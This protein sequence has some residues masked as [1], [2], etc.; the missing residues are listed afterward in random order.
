LPPNELPRQ[1][2]AATAT[3]RLQLGIVL[4]IW[5][6]MLA[7]ALGLVT[8]YGSNVPSWD[9]WDMV[10]FVTGHHPITMKWLWS[11]HNEHRVLLP[12][13]LFL[14]L[15]RLVTMDFRIGMYANVLGTGVLALALIFSARRLRGRS[16]FLDAFFP[17]LLLNWGQAANILWC[18]QLQFY[19][20]MLLAG[21]ILALISCALT[22]PKLLPSAAVGTCVLL[23]PLCGANGVSLVPALALWLE[24]GAVLH[25]RTGTRLG[26]RNA[27]ILSVFA[28]LGVLFVG[29]YFLGYH[30]V[31]YHP[32]TY[33][34][35]SVCRTAV[36]FITM[37]FG[38]GVVGLGFDR[39]LPM[40]LWEIVCAAVAVL[41]VLT[42]WRLV[43]TWRTQP[44]ECARAAG[45]VLYLAAMLSLALGIGLGRNGF[46]TRYVTLSVP[47]L[48][49]VYLAWSIYGSLHMQ[50]VVRAALFVTSAIVLFPNIGWGLLYARDLRSH[51]AAFEKD[52]LTGMPP[53]QLIQRHARYLHLHHTVLMDYMPMLRR[54]GVGSFRYLGDDPLFREIRLAAEGAAGARTQDCTDRPD[55]SGGWF[56]FAL[57]TDVD[58]AGIRLS[59]M[60]KSVEGTAPYVVICWKST[61]E[62]DFGADSYIAYSPSGDQANWER[63]TWLRS[64]TD[65]SVVYVWLGRPVHQVRVWFPVRSGTTAK[66]H[67]VALLV[68]V[69]NRP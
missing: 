10:P 12:R 53:Y 24:Y 52:M 60:Y 37:G 67:D 28:L 11:Q 45:I 23:L 47:A 66:I 57:P 40:P 46:E 34:P 9:D 7:G 43:R 36:Q 2:T 22:P 31:P 41:F 61:N 17:L 65:D 39:R 5:T 49:A 59:Y 8:E 15:M 14:G 19:A 68:P 58:A 51:L 18:W 32:S 56:R 62:K 48:C 3:D 6:A 21:A 25:W 50:R 30:K 1:A 26:K 55:G 38:P 20:S 29:L 44:N 42:G 35:L 69:D 63:G 64:N 33:R 54:A 16:S 4:L 27:I 13:L